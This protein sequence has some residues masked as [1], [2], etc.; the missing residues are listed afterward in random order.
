MISKTVSEF[1]YI[2]DEGHVAMPGLKFKQSYHLEILACSA[3]ILG[4]ILKN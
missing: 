1:R 4:L 2:A 3:F